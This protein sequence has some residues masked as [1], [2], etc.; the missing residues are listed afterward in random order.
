MTPGELH[1][2]MKR[3][4][5]EQ[6]GDLAGWIDGMARDGTITLH[7]SAHQTAKAICAHVDGMLWF[8]LAQ[9][10]ALDD[11]L[12]EISAGLDRLVTLG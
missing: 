7:M 8:A 12:P 6:I 4:L 9:D 1:D 10:Q 3:L 5:D 2:T 11:A